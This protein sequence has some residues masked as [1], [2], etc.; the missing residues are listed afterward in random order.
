M[1]LRGQWKDFIRRREGKSL[2]RSC[3]SLRQKKTVRA[4]S[5]RFQ[6]GDC[7]R[8][9]RIGP[10]RRGG[11]DVELGDAARRPVFRRP[12]SGQQRRKH[13]GKSAG[14]LGTHAHAGG[15]MTP[16]TTPLTTTP[17]AGAAA[18][19]NSPQ[20]ILPLVEKY[21]ARG[22]ALRNWFQAFNATGDRSGCFDLIK[23]F[24]RPEFSYGFF[25]DLPAPDGAIP[26]IGS[27]Q[28]MLYDRTR[29]PEAES[30]VDY[31][32]LRSQLH[33]FVL[34][35]FLRISSFRPAE[36]TCDALKPGLAARSPVNWCTTPTDDRE[37][38]GFTQWF[39][40]LAGS[41]EIV[42]FPHEQRETICDL[43][44]IGPVYEW[45]VLK[46]NIYDFTFRFNLLKPGGPA[47]ALPLPESSYLVVTREF[48]HDETGTEGAT[49]GFGYAF[50][51]SA[52]DSFLAYGPGQFDAAWQQIEFQIQP[53][54]EIKARLVFVANEPVNITRI[55]LNPVSLGMRLADWATRGAAAPVLDPLARWTPELLRPLS[56]VDPVTAFIDLANRLTGGAAK[57]VCISRRHLAKV[58]LYQ[59]YLQHYQAV[60][61]SLTTWR[62]IPDWTDEAALPDWVRSGKTR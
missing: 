47:L 9:E 62:Q 54:G 60:S 21:L 18:S 17:H 22:R 25:A 16:A 4:R 32:W 61:G 5:G 28:E 24:N 12:S 52:D 57:S 34:R 6:C 15:V 39:A 23:T 42:Q 51:H 29:V 8:F 13:S 43:R 11:A 30:G 56:A 10:N 1:W 45:L 2:G 50:I 14:R 35:Y 38:F 31:L 19:G 40:K 59:H 27:V 37:G 49:Y 44:E 46:V 20:S 33:E 41:G 48:I 53:Q 55:D 36:E 7:L 26:I 3:G 58:F